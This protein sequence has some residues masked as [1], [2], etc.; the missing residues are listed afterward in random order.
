M[1]LSCPFVYKTKLNIYVCVSQFHRHIF[2]MKYIQIFVC[3]SRFSEQRSDTYNFQVSYY[4]I[5]AASSSF[6][7]VHSFLFF[8]RV[9][10]R[11]QK[12]IS[13]CGRLY[14]VY[15]TNQHTHKLCFLVHVWL[16]NHQA[17]IIR[18]FAETGLFNIFFV[19]FDGLRV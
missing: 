7:I 15:H 2:K 3:I 18:H 6:R 17:D 1:R 10:F 16:V 5:N 4:K 8:M 13:S 19:L 9:M 11:E 14:N 12:Y